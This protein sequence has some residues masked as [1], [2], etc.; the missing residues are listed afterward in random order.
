MDKA[1]F[2]LQVI[3]VSMIGIYLF[4]M[5]ASQTS[6]QGLRDFAQAL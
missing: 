2:W 3:I 5:F 4:K 1:M 6:V